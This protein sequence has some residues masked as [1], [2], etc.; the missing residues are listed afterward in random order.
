MDKNKFDFILFVFFLELVMLYRVFNLKQD[1]VNT[2]P[3]I[4]YIDTQDVT[5]MCGMILSSSAL[6][7]FDLSIST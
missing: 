5:S 4:I 3:E 2:I 6:K 7:S 1:G